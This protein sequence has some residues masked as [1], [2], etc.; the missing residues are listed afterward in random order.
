MALTEAQIDRLNNKLESIEEMLEI[1]RRIVETL[2]CG[3]CA[4]CE[5]DADHAIQEAR[6]A[7]REL[8]ACEMLGSDL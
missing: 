8:L 2:E 3:E 5:S 7:A 1:A 6:A 4:E